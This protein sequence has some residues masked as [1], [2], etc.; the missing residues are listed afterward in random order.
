MTAQHT[1]G[2]VFWA[3]PSDLEIAENLSVI[4]GGGEGRTGERA[5][6]GIW[7]PH[8]NSRALLTAEQLDLLIDWLKE[9]RSALDNELPPP[10][11]S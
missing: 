4:V 11:T 10:K 1:D 5:F 3:E 8:S 6:L 7:T 9:T 2:F